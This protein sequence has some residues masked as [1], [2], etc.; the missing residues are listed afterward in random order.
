MAR[1][2]L[3]QFCAFSLRIKAD[4]ADLR[5]SV[6]TNAEADAAVDHRKSMT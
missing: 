3:G 5:R 2:A 4:N 6:V 1:K